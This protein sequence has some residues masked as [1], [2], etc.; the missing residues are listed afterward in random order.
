MLRPLLS[1]KLLIAQSALN[2]TANLD[3][4][5]GSKAE[6]TLVV[7]TFGAGTGAG[8]VVVEG[9]ADYAFAGTW[10]VLATMTW[11][12]ASRAHETFIAGGY[13]ARRV[14]ISTG[15]TGGTVDVDFLITG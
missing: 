1:G 3:E 5:S 11:A 2:T 6:G 10:A 7:V 9:A 13:L 15:V 8:A 12:A 4:L 14:R